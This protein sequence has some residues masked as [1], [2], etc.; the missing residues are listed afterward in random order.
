[1]IIGSKVYDRFDTSHQYW[2]KLDARKESL[3]K[4]LGY[5]EIEHIDNPRVLTIA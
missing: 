1:M 2:E 4:C 5:F 3:H